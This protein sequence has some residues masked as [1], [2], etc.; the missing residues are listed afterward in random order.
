[1]IMAISSPYN[2]YVISI[3][4]NTFFFWLPWSIA[5]GIAIA[6]LYVLDR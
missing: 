4:I 6:I 3:R 5:L 2:G 1:M